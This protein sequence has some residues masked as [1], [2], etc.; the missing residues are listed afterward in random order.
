M[1]IV[2]VACCLWFT[3]V[4]LLVSCGALRDC[5]EE[6][7]FAHDTIVCLCDCDP[8]YGCPRGVE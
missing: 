7:M 2:L 6:C 5:E 3:L 1:M 8:G 4:G